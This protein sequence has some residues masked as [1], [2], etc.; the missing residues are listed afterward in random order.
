MEKVVHKPILTEVIRKKGTQRMNN[1][2]EKMCVY[3]KIIAVKRKGG[4]KTDKERK[5]RQG[6]S[7]LKK[8]N[9]FRN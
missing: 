8:S 3:M 5:K 1:Y 7:T 2:T 6:N 9:I 4:L